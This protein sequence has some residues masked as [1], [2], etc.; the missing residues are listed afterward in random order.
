[1]SEAR[2]EPPVLFG[3]ADH[4]RSLRAETG[5]A[6]ATKRPRIDR[7]WD[8]NRGLEAFSCHRPNRI[9]NAGLGEQERR[10]EIT[11]TTPENPRL[12][13]RSGRPNGGCAGAIRGMRQ[14]AG[15]AVGPVRAHWYDR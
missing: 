1:M 14:N 5:Q 3:V 11:L 2:L 9:T 8:A 7:G 13:D 10:V 12:T 15:G 4:E 6:V